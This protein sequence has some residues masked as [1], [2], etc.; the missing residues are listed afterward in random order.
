MDTAPLVGTASPYIVMVN[1]FFLGPF[2]AVGH[3]LEH[4]VK[5]LV[6][7]DIL[8]HRFL[9]GL[10]HQVSRMALCEPHNTHTSPI[11]LQ[12]VFTAAK[13]VFNQLAGTGADGISPSQETRSEL[14]PL[15]I[16]CSSG[17]CSFKVV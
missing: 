15:T 8:C 6:G 1:D 13:D 4:E 14:K 17:M 10:L 5:I 12:W 11:C 2:R 16:L 3:L 7:A 9:A